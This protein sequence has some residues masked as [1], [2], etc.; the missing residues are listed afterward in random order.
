MAQVDDHARLEL[1]RSAE[2]A[3]GTANANTLMSLLPPVGWADIATKHDLDQLE[4][5]LELRFEAKLERR[6]GDQTRILVFAI[7]GAFMTQ[8][9]IVLSAIALTR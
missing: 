6:L 1:H 7:L 5:R 2:A 4:L 8:T 9:A 3:F